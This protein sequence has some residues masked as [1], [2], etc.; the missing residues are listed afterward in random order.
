MVARQRQSLHRRH[1]VPDV[2]KPRRAC[3]IRDR[4]LSRL[5]VPYSVMGWHDGLHRR[6]KRPSEHGAECQ[7]AC[8]E[9]PECSDTRTVSTINR[10]L[11]CPTCGHV[12]TEDVPRIGRTFVNQPVSRS[13]RALENQ[14]HI[15][16]LSAREARHPSPTCPTCHSPDTETLAS[17][18][19]MHSDYAAFC[20][21]VCGRVW[22]GAKAPPAATS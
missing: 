19:A 1:V 18:S 7:P 5:P 21:R 20:C 6:R 17:P 2:G 10:A 15:S 9:C 11:Y 22:V 12:W 14:S 3:A 4:S 13:R 16:D 8:P